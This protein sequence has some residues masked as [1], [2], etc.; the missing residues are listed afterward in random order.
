MSHAVDT[1]PTRRG[2]LLR[3]EVHRLRS[4]RLV[5]GL[6]ALAVLG[7]L[8]FAVVRLTQHAATS[9]A[10]L[11]EAQT[12]VDQAVAQQESYRQECLAQPLPAGV[13]AE[14]ACGPAG[15]AGQFDVTDFL[16]PP[17][18]TLATDFAPSATGVG[19]AAGA[20]AFLIGVSFVGAEWSQHTM[21][22]LLLWV[23]RRRTVVSR[24][25]AVATLA[26]A[27][28]S[29]LLGAAW[30]ATAWLLG[31]VR[32]STAV[33][34][35]FWTDLAALE[36]RLVLL[37]ALL[38]LAGAALANTVRGTG[39]A[40]GLALGYLVL[41]ETGVRSIGGESQRWLLS[42]SAEALG[43]LS[44]ASFYVYEK[45]PQP[46]G[47]FDYAGREILVTGLQGGMVLAVTVAVLVTVGTVLFLR[48]DLQ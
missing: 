37:G 16:Q 35:G 11:A 38:G 20:L 8:A 25:L 2:S 46:G 32:G 13:A 26:G 14:Q 44:G 30:V 5:L 28:V 3:A 17:P 43:N 33:G 19:M 15:A 27:L 41:V 48:R 47:G 22:A 29:L 45:K 34:D 23:P 36:A 40:L 21:V 6:L 31:T 1:R 39:A 4:R 12:R 9:P 7:F 42:V 18:F 24:K 10:G